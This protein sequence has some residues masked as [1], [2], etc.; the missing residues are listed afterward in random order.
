M[1]PASYTITASLQ[2]KSFSPFS[3]ILPANAVAN[4]VAVNA[5]YSVIGKAVSPDNQPLSGIQVT[6]AEQN[7]TV[8]TDNQGNFSFSLPLGAKYHIQLRS[9]RYDMYPSE[10]VGEVHGNVA[11]LSVGRTGN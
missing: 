10:L 1:G 2:G 3:G 9:D 7:T 8:I 11:R 4:F 6:L 5:A